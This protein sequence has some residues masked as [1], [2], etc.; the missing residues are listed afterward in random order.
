MKILSV[1]T[2][3]YLSLLGVLFSGARLFDPGTVGSFA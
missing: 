3:R 1:S 2:D